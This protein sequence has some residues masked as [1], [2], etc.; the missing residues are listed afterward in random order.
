MLRA[1]II[2][3]FIFFF[4]SCNNN[5]S[6]ISVNINAATETPLI[7]YAVINSFPHDTSL[8]TEGFLFHNG[9]LFESTGSPDELPRTKS[10]IVEDNL[11]TGSFDNKV[12][13]DRTKYF[14][15]GICF[16]N[17]KLYEL[18][19]KNQFC[20]VYN[21]KTFKL[22]D[23]FKYAN[24]EGWSLTSD[25]TNLIMSDG[26]DTLT[27]INSENFKPVK[28]LAVIE[29]G[30]PL[31]N[32]NE[33]EYINGFIYANVWETNYVVKIDTLTGKVVGKL[34]LSSLTAEAKNKNP[35]TD[36]LNGIAYD[37]ATDKIYV[38]GKLW[39]NIYQVSFSH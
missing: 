27:Y 13:I 2:A 24:I 3:F 8:F 19:Y 17:N 30:T 14:G 26:T 11:Q 10:L 25:K 6:S 18:T 12:E 9:Q 35:Y 20:F 5:N 28:T 16:F 22:L 37:S 21:A 1:I 33:L 39:S 36:V 31:K 15:E 34:D 23:S 7:N 38:T 32:L 4:L 29:N